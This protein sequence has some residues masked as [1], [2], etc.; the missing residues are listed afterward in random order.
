VK[1]LAVPVVVALMLAMSIVTLPAQARLQIVVIEGE[2]AVNVIQQRTA[3]APIVEVRDSNGQPVGGAIV[4][5][6]V[7]KGRATFNGAKSM[8]VTTNAA[9]RANAAGFTPTGAGPLQVT[10]TATYQGLTAATTIAQTAVMTAAAAG[11][12]GAGAAEAGAAAAGASG[13]AAAGGGISATTLAIVGGAAAGG[14]LAVK[15]VVNKVQGGDKYSG[16]AKASM[17]EA[18]N[19]SSGVTCL[20]T[21]VLDATLVFHFDA[22]NAAV[23]G[24]A[25]ANGT[26]GPT[27]STCP[28]VPVGTTELPWEH[29][30]ING[31]T[32]S[33][34]VQ[35]SY[36]TVL[37]GGLNTTQ[38]SSGKFVG[39]LNGST[40]TGTLT[41]TQQDDATT[42]KGFAT[43]TVPISL[44]KQ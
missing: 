19:F 21:L 29:Q 39:A 40:I 31:T 16:Q 2:D 38:T 3:V 1:R 35:F 43:T 7:S 15:Q 23:S 14:A 30:P 44:Q 20:N 27:S 17:V 32:S 34:T 4:K 6:A 25:E 18:L 22:N 33:I 9:G 26:A 8:S 41:W 28:S 11:A 42:L 37:P 36:S 10:A 24:E 13:A 5:F 12:A